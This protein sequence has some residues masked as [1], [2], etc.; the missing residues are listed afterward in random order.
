MSGDF[1]VFRNKAG[2]LALAECAD[3]VAG[4]VFCGRAA[5]SC[6]VAA[7]PYGPFG[8]DKYLWAQRF[9]IHRH[10]V[11]PVTPLVLAAAIALSPSPSTQPTQVVRE[12]VWNFHVVLCRWRT[13]DPPPDRR[14]KVPTTSGS[15]QTD[16]A[17]QTVCRV[18]S[19]DAGPGSMSPGDPGSAGAQIF[20][21]RSI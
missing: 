5:I 16:C 12:C 11:S 7:C 13:V 6:A 14:E 9:S 1:N 17:A 3:G 2:E 19:I 21:A 10:G 18:I 15:V 20:N 4:L 8:P